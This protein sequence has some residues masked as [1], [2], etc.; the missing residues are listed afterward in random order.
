[1]SLQHLN[2]LRTQRAGGHR[3]RTRHDLTIDSDAPQFLVGSGDH[4]GA[5]VAEGGLDLGSDLAA[6]HGLYELLLGVGPRG[7]LVALVSEA[8][9]AGRELCGEERVRAVA[10]DRCARERIIV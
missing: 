2:E 10:D 9:R 8:G 1:M 4:L 6:L 7:E 3:V 5:L